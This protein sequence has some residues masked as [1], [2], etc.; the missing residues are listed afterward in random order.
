MSKDGFHGR[1]DKE[2]D[3][4]PI[5]SDTILPTLHNR[6]FTSITGRWV[7][8]LKVA[9][10][11]RLEGELALQTCPRFVVSPSTDGTTA[12][13]Q[14]EYMFERSADT[15]GLGW[16]SDNTERNYAEVTVIV[17]GEIDL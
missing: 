12:R 13:P 4:S 6:I 8:K 14:G 3:D 5:F 9:L 16:K 11:P 15:Y 2:E 1:I 17:V 10:H 7:Y